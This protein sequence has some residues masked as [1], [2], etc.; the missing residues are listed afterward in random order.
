[1]HEVLDVTADHGLNLLPEPSPGDIFFDLEGDPF[2]GLNGREYL[3]G[4][5]LADGGPPRYECR[6]ALSAAKER[7][8]FIWF[9][10]LVTARWANYPSM[11]I[12]HFAPYEP[13]ALKRLMGR[14]GVGEDEVDRMLRA[15]L[16]VD[17][18]TVLKRSV[19]ASVE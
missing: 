1:M 14:Y 3:F 16:F 6:W 13:S 15:N 19:R 5:V 11:H 8:A 2:V 10:D 4:A 9:V 12:Y 7:D 18:H 17:L